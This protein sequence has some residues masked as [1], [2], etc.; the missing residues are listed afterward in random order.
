MTQLYPPPAD[1]AV[2]AYEGDVRAPARPVRRSPPTPAP[3]PRVLMLNYEYPPF[4]GGTGIA[5]M[6]L[7]QTLVADR[8]VAV[9]LVTSG[10]GPGVQRQRL[11]DLVAIHH[12]P[13][14]KRDRQLWRASELASWTVKAFAYSRGLIG[15]GNY[16]LCHCW[17]SWP[18]GVIGHAFRQKLPYIVSLRGSD[19]P[20]YNDRLRLLDPLVLRHLARRVWFAAERVLAVSDSLRELAL[21]TRSDATIEVARNGIDLQRFRPGDVVGRPDLL[22]VGR[23]IERKGVDHLVE[24]F[25]RISEI[26]PKITLSI[27]GGGPQRPRLEAMSRERGLES[28]IGFCGQLDLAG[29]AEAYRQAG[30]LLLPALADALPNVVLEAMASGLAIVTTRTGAAEMIRDNG[31]VIESADPAAITGAVERYLNDRCLLV[32]HQRNSRKL[33]LAMPWSTVAGFYLSIYRD[34][35]ARSGR[36]RVSHPPPLQP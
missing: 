6:Q 1:A 11:S 16:D 19:V 36:S 20:G 9:D 26:D 35:L 5:C 10:P 3:V 30:I 29:V 13:I 14:G 15:A 22:F 21:E 17:G 8:S 12:L 2:L 4:G 23:L 18:A 27:V 31:I 34:A 24:A 7:L 28:R 32:Q 25:R 33:A